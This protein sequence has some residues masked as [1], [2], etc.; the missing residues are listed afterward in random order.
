MLSLAEVLPTFLLRTLPSPNKNAAD[1]INKIGL[2]NR[3]IICFTICFSYFFV[4]AYA[5][6]PLRAKNNPPTHIKTC[7][8]S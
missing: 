6:L 5:L 7:R 2:L 8:L 3:F 1:K 4:K